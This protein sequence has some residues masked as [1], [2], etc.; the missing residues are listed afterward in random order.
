MISIGVTSSDRNS[1]N[2]CRTVEKLYKSARPPA[3][4]L[5]NPLIFRNATMLAWDLH[6]FPRYAYSRNQGMEMKHRQPRQIQII[7]HTDLPDGSY[8]MPQESQ[9]AGTA[10]PDGAPPGWRPSPLLPT[11]A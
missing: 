11:P 8:G 7:M 10:S 3:L 1:Q 9:D 4:C 2:D 6:P 5:S